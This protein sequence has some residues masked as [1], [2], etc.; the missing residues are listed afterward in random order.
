[1]LYALVFF[2]GFCLGVGVVLLDL[3]LKHDEH[4]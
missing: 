1:M 4:D 3:E 2:G